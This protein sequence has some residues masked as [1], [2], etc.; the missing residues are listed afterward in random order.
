MNTKS[1]THLSASIRRLVALHPYAGL[2]VT[3]SLFVLVAS[4]LHMIP[5]P[6]LVRS[7]EKESGAVVLIAGLLT[8]GGWWKAAGFTRG[9]N[10]QTPIL[11]LGTLIL[12]SLPLLPSFPSLLK[13][14]LSVTGLAIVLAL[15]IGFVEEGLFRGIVGCLLLPKG[16]WRYVLLSTLLF[17]ALHALHFFDA[18]PRSFVLGQIVVALGM[19][20]LLAAIRV[21]TGSIWPAILLHALYDFPSVAALQA[22]SPTQGVSA[23]V[24]LLLLAASVYSLFF[25]LSAMILLRPSKLHQVSIDSGLPPPAPMLPVEQTFLGSF[26]KKEWVTRRSERESLVECL[27]IQGGEP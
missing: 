20:T 13:V 8:L 18:L 16:I 21:R 5:G 7:L 11:C 4:L 14:P 23:P 3:I 26:P 19:G 15:L 9:G 24:A 10:R 27:S 22:N 2:L 12:L 6:F 1:S 17:A 25:L